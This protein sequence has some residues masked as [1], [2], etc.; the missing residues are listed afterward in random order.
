MTTAVTEG[1][2]VTDVAQYQAMCPPRLH[3]R[4]CEAQRQQSRCLHRGRRL[5]TQP[6]LPVSPVPTHHHL[7][8][9]CEKHRVAPP[10]H[11]LAHVQQFERV[12]ELGMIAIFRVPV[13]QLPVLVPP[14]APRATGVTNG[15]SVRRPERHLT[16]KDKIQFS[17]KR[18]ED[19]RNQCENIHLYQCTHFA[20]LNSIVTLRRTDL[21]STP[22]SSKRGTTF[23]RNDA[24]TI[25][26]PGF[27]ARD[28]RFSC[29][30]GGWSKG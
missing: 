17:V 26:Y 22:S 18:S 6:Q 13:A 9:I 1:I 23:G 28:T 24:A 10:R 16:E 3:V 5:V 25:P 11:H 30:C 2:D 19:V 7:R 4:G 15:N 21:M 20:T 8:P 29:C 14:E 27:G 12:Y